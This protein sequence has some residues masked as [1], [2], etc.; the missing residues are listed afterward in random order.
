MT[1]KLELIIKSHIL[2]SEE[3]DIHAVVEYKQE[4]ENGKSFSYSTNIDFYAEHI[5]KDTGERNDV[6][7]P[8][9]LNKLNVILEDYANEA[10]RY[11]PDSETDITDLNTENN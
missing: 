4:V 9:T 8:I 7:N 10:L 5:D 11:A 3:Y 6:I 2:D 1:T